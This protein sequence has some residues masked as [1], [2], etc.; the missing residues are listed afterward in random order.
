MRKLLPVAAL[1]ASASL[2]APAAHASLI[3]IGLQEAGVNSGNIT[4]VATDN[5]SGVASYGS[6]SDQASGAYGT[7][8]VNLITATGS[9]AIT[10]PNL[11]STALNVS[12]SSAGVLDVYITES[13][14]SSPVG[15][16]DLMSA[17][18]A[19]VFNG[20]VSSVVE[21][22]YISTSNASY[23]GTLLASNAFTG[24]GTQTFT[25]ATPLLSDPYSETMEYVITTTGT[26]DV[27]DTIDIASV[28]EPGSVA[29]L[30][31]GLLALGLLLRRRRSA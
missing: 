25:D 12:G 31:S 28:P 16:N 13:G 15:V 6:S 3:S 30:G 8:T 22:T 26:A 23:G 2:C 19:N 5:G 18:T 20:A 1:L 27:N 9:P 17:F 29:L 24:I 10:S 11:D 14:L 21:S 7:F 4:T